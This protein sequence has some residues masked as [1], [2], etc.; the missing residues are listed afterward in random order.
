MKIKISSRDAFWSYASVILSCGINII[1]MP[2]ILIFLNDDDVAIYYVFTNLA[3]IAV[4]FDFGFSPSIAR[5]MTYAWSGA[6]E[7]ISYCVLKIT[8]QNREPN[9]KLIKKLMYSCKVIYFFLAML[10]FIFCALFGTVYINHITKDIGVGKYILPWGIYVIAIFLN[11]LYGY[12]TVY[13]RGVGA[14]SNVNISMVVARCVQLVVVV[15][16]LIFGQGLLG[17]SVAYLMYGVTFRFIAKKKYYAFQGIKQKLERESYKVKKNDITETLK[18][19]WPNTWKDGVVTLSNYMLLQTMTILAPFFLSLVE[20]GVY[21]M[22]VQLVTVIGTVASNLLVACNPTIQSSYAIK[23][24]EMVKR[25]FSLAITAQMYIFLLGIFALI[26]IG[27]PIIL[28]LKPSYSMDNTVI[29]AVSI[30]QY[31]ILHR[32][33]FCGYISNTNRLIYYKSFLMSSFICV[34]LAI[35]LAPNYGVYGL[36]A[37]QIISQIAYNAWKWPMVVRKELNISNKEIF[38]LGNEEIVH[39]IFNRGN[40][41]N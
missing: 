18:I 10:C 29:I 1:I 5:S 12:Y 6:K 33:C 16:L 23:D 8:D 37:A 24:F 13:L 35:I 7:L 40:L 41:S 38:K 22:S 19:I 25:K 14:I 28:L 34:L 30:S 31:I 2:L 36:V 4:L 21:S 15:A 20:A 17:V 3:T 32:N 27:K 26:V 39:I 11:V 9:F